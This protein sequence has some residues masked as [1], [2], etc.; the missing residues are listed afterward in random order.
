MEKPEQ[1]EDD[2]EIT[3]IRNLIGALS[4]AFWREVNRRN[5]EAGFSPLEY[6]ITHYEGECRAETQEEVAI[7]DELTK[8]ENY[9]ALTRYV[10]GCRG[11]VNEYA[12]RLHTALL[13]M[14]TRR[15]ESESQEEPSKPTHS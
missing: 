6:L 4:D 1:P 7:W 14:A 15:W 11:R 13:T 3:R 9:L 12:E 2:P 10:E 8:P 5:G